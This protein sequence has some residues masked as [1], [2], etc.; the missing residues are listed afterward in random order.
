M[1]TSE[2]S[3]TLVRIYSSNIPDNYI[4]MTSR[5]YIAQAHTTCIHETERRRAI[6]EACLR[7]SPAVGEGMALPPSIMPP[8][9][10]P[11]K[12]SEKKR[13]ST[14]TPRAREFVL[15]RHHRANGADDMIRRTYEIPPPKVTGRSWSSAVFLGSDGSTGWEAWCRHGF[16]HHTTRTTSTD[17]NARGP[18][19]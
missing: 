7:R 13:E 8:M 6:G 11:K 17:Y 2:S 9:P 16:R 15:T 10:T 3:R 12:K 1:R 14:S 4:C 18:R 19:Y 5:P